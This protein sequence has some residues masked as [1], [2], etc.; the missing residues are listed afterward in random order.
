MQ[1][2]MPKFAHNRALLRTLAV[3]TCVF[4]GILALRA[5]VIRGVVPTDISTALAARRRLRPPQRLQPG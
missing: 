5:L 4:A 2:K 3:V 1:S